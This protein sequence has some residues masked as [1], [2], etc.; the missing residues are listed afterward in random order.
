[1]S[2]K[3]TEPKVKYAHDLT[4]IPKDQLHK[5]HWQDVDALIEQAKAKLPPTP[6]QLRYARDLGISAAEVV[7]KSQADVHAMIAE[8]LKRLRREQLDRDRTAP[9]RR[10]VALRQSFPIGTRV[11][12]VLAG[13]PYDGQ[14]ATVIRHGRINI[15]LQFADGR[16]LVVSSDARLKKITDS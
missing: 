1:M 9:R 5:M 10:S 6:K 8:K 14:T 7:G 13:S 4:G 11:R 15:T 3:P 16:C 12:Y 2:K